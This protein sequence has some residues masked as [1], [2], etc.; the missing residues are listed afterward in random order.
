MLPQYICIFGSFLPLF[1][2]VADKSVRKCRRRKK[3]KRRSPARNDLWTS[4]RW[5]TSLISRSPWT[6]IFGCFGWFRGQMT[7]VSF[8]QLFTQFMSGATHSAWPAP[9][10]WCGRVVYWNDQAWQLLLWG[11]VIQRCRGHGGR[12]SVGGQDLICLC[13][14]EC[15]KLNWPLAAIVCLFW[16]FV[17]GCVCSCVCA[18]GSHALE[19]VVPTVLILLSPFHPFFLSAMS[20]RLGFL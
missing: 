9:C 17:Y 14:G 10:P 1:C 19:H 8:H 13:N 5:Y 15:N 3:E 2:I 16:L 7:R 18:R 12:L 20:P 6:P 11:D 4:I